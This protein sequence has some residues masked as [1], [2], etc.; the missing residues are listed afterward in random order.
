MKKIIVILIFIITSLIISEVPAQV[1]Q[2]WVATYGGVGTGYNTPRKSSVDKFGNY[3]VAGSSENSV[4]YDYIVLK[5]NTSGNLL[6][7]R[8]YN[9]PV[10]RKDYLTDMVLDDSGNVYVTGES[11]VETTG[12]D[13]DWITIKYKPN[14]DTAWIRSFEWTG[15]GPDEPF[16]MA[17]DNMNNIYITGFCLAAPPNGMDM[18][19]AKY[20]SAGVLQWAR[21]YSSTQ[22]APDWGY[23]ICTDDSN[24]V[25]S[26]G[27]GYAGG[28][29]EIVT[30]KY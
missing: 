30:I 2:E 6:W 10:N 3:I 22:N 12:G 21:S 29:N 25:Y 7:S 18:V 26:S 9:S 24:N 19:T 14:G 27:Y 23:A 20:N 4:D 28:N 17:L 15:E 1:T 5:Y 13:L 8:R 11:Y 16:G